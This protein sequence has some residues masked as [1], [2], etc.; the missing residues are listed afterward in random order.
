MLRER[1]L[2]QRD[3]WLAEWA[4]HD[5][6]MAIDLR[7]QTSIAAK[8]ETLPSYALQCFEN[9]A[10]QREARSRAEPS[11]PLHERRASNTHPADGGDQDKI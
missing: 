9:I 11:K 2:A 4:E 10:S 8:E 5:H 1:K 6:L 7:S 3:Y